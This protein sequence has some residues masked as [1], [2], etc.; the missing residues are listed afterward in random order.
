MSEKINNLLNELNSLQEKEKQLISLIEN[1]LEE[2]LKIIKEEKNNFVLKQDWENAAKYRFD[3]M[4]NLKNYIKKI[5]N[6]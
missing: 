4:E 6:E 3:D 2:E 5:N 1:N